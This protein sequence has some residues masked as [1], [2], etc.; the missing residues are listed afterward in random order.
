MLGLGLGLAV[1]ISLG[2]ATTIS[3]VV[4]SVVLGRGLSLRSVSEKRIAAVEKVLGV[5]SGMAITAL[6]LLFLSM[7]Y[8]A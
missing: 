7:T 4:V 8:S 2:M 5:V 3:L 1:C 6:G